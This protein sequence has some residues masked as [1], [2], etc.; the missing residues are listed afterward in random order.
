MV[1]ETTL[2]CFYNMADIHIPPPPP[3]VRQRGDYWQHAILPSSDPLDMAMPLGDSRFTKQTRKAFNPVQVHQPT[4]KTRYPQT[5][6]Q[7]DQGRE[8]VGTDCDDA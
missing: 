5:M 4:S 7:I 8:P 3:L 6:V 1:V 2:S